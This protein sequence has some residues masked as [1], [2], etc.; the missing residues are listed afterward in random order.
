LFSNI[1]QFRVFFVE[2]V[3]FF[4]LS[5]S[6]PGRCKI[7]NGDC[8]HASRDGHTFSACSVSDLQVFCCCLSH[9][10]SMGAPLLVCG[11]CSHF[12]FFFL[13]LCEQDNGEVKCQCPPGFKGDG[14]KSCE[15]KRQTYWLKLS[16]ISSHDTN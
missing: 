15:G 9:R 12:F 2:S 16:V 4:W 6:G 10:L 1:L 5:A 13:N 7:N 8:W 14:V 11:S 3:L